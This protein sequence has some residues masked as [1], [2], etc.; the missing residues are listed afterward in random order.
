MFK[1]LNQKFFALNKMKHIDIIINTFNRLPYLEKCIWSIIASISMPYRITVIDDLSTDGTRAWLKL[2]KKRGLIHNVIL[3]KAKLGSAETLNFAISTTDSKWFIF[4]ND[5]M[6]FHRGWL[7]AC[8]QI[9]MDYQN[10]GAISFFDYTNLK[11]GKNAI[12]TKKRDCYTLKASGLGA[13][14]MNRDLWKKTGGFRIKGGK[15]M[16]FF[17]SDFCEQLPKLQFV[18]RG[19][20]Q[21]LL[22][23]ATHMDAVKCKLNERDYSESIG[24]HAF[25]KK[26]K[27]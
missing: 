2:M 10:C 4:A 21:T 7:S 13:T 23:W 8:A 25:R 6:W 9:A 22:P 16:G 18:R 15:K 19:L 26:N 20:Y 17:A 3:P 27:K 1:K 14:M 12:F 24:Y 11:V 5:D